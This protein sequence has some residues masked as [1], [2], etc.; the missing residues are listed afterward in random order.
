MEI[1]VNDFSGGLNTDNSKLN[2]PQGTYRYMLNGMLISEDG[3]LFNPVNEKGTTNKVLNFPTGYKIIGATV[4]NTEFIVF[5]VNPTSGNSEAGEISSSYVY[6][7]KA[8]K[9]AVGNQLGLTI[10]KQ[11]TCTARKLLTGDRVVYFADYN[12]PMRF[13]N[14]GNSAADV[15][16]IPADADLSD[17]STLIASQTVPDI[18]LSGIDE[19]FGELKNGVYQFVTRYKTQNLNSTSFG[20]PCN[21]IPIVENRLSEGRSRYDGEYEDYGDVAKTI[22]LTI[23]NIDTSYPYLEVIVI[24]YD[25]STGT[26]IAKALPLLNITSSTLSVSYNGTEEDVTDITQQELAIL[27]V[28]YNT[29]KVLTQKDDVLFASNLKDTSSSFDTELQTIANNIRI[30]YRTEEIEYL[31]GNGATTL[32][33]FGVTSTPYILA[34]PTNTVYVLFNQVVDVTSAQTVANYTLKDGGGA[35]FTPTSATVDPVNKNLVQLIFAFAT[36]DQTHTLRI[37]ASI[38]NQSLTATYNSA[39]V[40]LPI[41]AGQPF[42]VSGSSSTSAAQFNDYKSEGVC[43]NKVGYMRDETYSL[44]FGVL[45][46]DGSTSL[47]YHIPAS[48]AV[49]RANVNDATAIAAI[50][51]TPGVYAGAT[52]GETGVYH[53]TLQY[54]AGQNYPTNGKFNTSAVDGNYYIRHHKM[55]SLKQEPHFR[56]DAVTGKTYIRIIGLDFKFTVAPS[57]DL[58]KT[59][60]GIVFFR[61]RRNSSQ[62]KNI[63]AQGLLSRLVESANDYSYDTGTVN[64][65]SK[66]YKKMPFFNNTE[67][68]QT[69]TFVNQV[70]A[71]RNSA[72]IHYDYAAALMDKMALFTPET[73]FGRLKDVDLIGLTMRKEMKLKA[74][75]SI[76]KLDTTKYTAKNSILYGE[77]KLKSVPKVYLFGNYYKEDNS[78][79]PGVVGTNITNALSISDQN[80]ATVDSIG[81]DNSTSGKFMYIKTGSTLSAADFGYNNKITLTFHTDIPSSVGATRDY[82]TSDIFDIP[83]GDYTNNLMNIVSNNTQQYGAISGASCIAIYKSNVIPVTNQTIQAVYGGDTYISKFAYVNKDVFRFRALYVKDAIVPATNY[84]NADSDEA[85][86]GAGPGSNGFDCRALSYFFVESTVNCNYRHRFVDRS[87]IG[88]TTNGVTYYPYDSAST[89]LAE[90]PRNGDSTSYNTQYSFENIAKTFNVKTIAYSP[91]SAFENRT[92]YSEKAQQDDVLD[93]YRVFLQNSYHDIPKN[94]GPIWNTFVHDNTFYI[95]TTK[96]L[97]RSFVNEVA[98]QA[99]TVAEAVLGTGG[100]FSMPSK[101]IFTSEGGYAGTISQFAG[102]HTPFGYVFP[103]A[104]QGKIFLLGSGLEEISQYGISQYLNTNLNKDLKSASAYAGYIDNPSNPASMGI[105]ASYDNKYKR[106]IIVKR[107]SSADLTLSYSMLNKK[108]ASFHSYKPHFMLSADNQMFGFTNDTATTQMHEHNTGVRGVFYNQAA[109]SFIIEFIINDNAKADKVYDNIFIQSTAYNSAGN[110]LDLETFKSIDC[111]TDFKDTGVVALTCTNTFGDNSN[112]KKKK[113]QFQLKVPRNSVGVD[114]N[115]PDRMKGKYMSV[116]LSYPNTSDNKL[117]IHYIENHYRVIAR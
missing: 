44:M 79:T 78:I 37:N 45:F 63:Y 21:P 61:Q 3:D 60:K 55:P 34:S 86:P 42:Q 76:E 14:F 11:V 20:I 99:N 4:L 104:L 102:V 7:R 33:T 25:G 40:Y 103:D 2:Q 69:Q 80:S 114:A 85:L 27:P 54:P 26:L 98:L 73:H 82:T 68:K 15:S 10:G 18:T 41:S 111:I 112:V 66:V 93:N 117:L 17:D 92:I 36:I 56:Y 31:D 57:S 43:F 47:A 62:N 81:I 19:T 65:A 1:S 49:Y 108:W 46:T 24:Y 109:A 71:N 83:A 88:T 90:D 77:F 30:K 13:L 75:I 53:S 91:I 95:H 51:D 32:P 72:G 89:T 48:N 116:R 39:G 84:T 50:S 113:N 107:G 12:Q 70:L 74:S 35:T 58:A 16:K 23:S 5:L 100:I 101:E 106:F 52:T 29:C 67:L 59:I 105:L 38:S 64:N 28:S 97:W 87:V 115:F 96:S 94:T 22:N 8:P 6:T 9:T 110:Y